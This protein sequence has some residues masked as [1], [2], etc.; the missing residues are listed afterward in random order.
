MIEVK[1]DI[2]RRSCREAKNL[3]QDRSK[4]RIAVNQFDD[5]MM[6]TDKVLVESQPH[7][8]K[9]VNNIFNTVT[10][11]VKPYVKC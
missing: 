2:H 6:N 5:F 4:W 9:F 7:I 1:Q 10:L 8:Y 3:A 11:G